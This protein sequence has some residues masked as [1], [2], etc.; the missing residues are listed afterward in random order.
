MLFTHFNSSTSTCTSCKEVDRSFLPAQTISTGT[1][2]FPLL[3]SLLHP[4][5]PLGLLSLL[6]SVIVQ[7]FLCLLA[8]LAA[9]LRKQKQSLRWHLQQQAQASVQKMAHQLKSSDKEVASAVII[10]RG[11]LT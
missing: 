6:A 3:H 2:S 7:V 10:Q 11:K 5:Q 1:P 9:A 8:A 4:S